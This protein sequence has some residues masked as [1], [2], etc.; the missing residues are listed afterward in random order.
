MYKPLYNIFHKINGYTK[1]YN[2]SKYL[3]LIPSNKKN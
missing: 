3:T 2:G 1:D